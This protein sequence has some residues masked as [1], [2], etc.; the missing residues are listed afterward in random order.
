MYDRQYL[1]EARGIDT[2]NR[3]QACAQLFVEMNLT[4]TSRV[5][6]FRQCNARGEHVLVVE[7]V[8]D[9]A[10]IPGALR[11]YV[12]LALDKGVLQAFPAGV[13]ETSPGHFVAMPG[14]RFEPT[15]I[16]RRSDF[17]A[18]A[19]KLLELFFGE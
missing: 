13:Q 5:F 14:P 16:V 10:Q 8:I 4:R 3:G 9:N 12:Q 11:G 2:G 6:R 19:T 7:S 1:A 17:I 15:T 18:P